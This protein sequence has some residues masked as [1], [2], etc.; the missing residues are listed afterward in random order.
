MMGLPE[1]WVTD[2][3]HD[4][5]RTQQLKAIGNGVCPQQGAAALRLLLERAPQEAG[6]AP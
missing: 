6:T 4:L 3:A 2:P 5:S 1:G